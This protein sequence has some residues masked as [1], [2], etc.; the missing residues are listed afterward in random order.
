MRLVVLPL[1]ATLLAFHASAQEPWK[2]PPRGPV[3]QANKTVVFIASDYKNG[4]VIGVYRGFEQATAELGWTLT[5]LDGGGTKDKQAALLAKVVASRPDG[6]VFGGFDPDHFANH[7]AAAKR[8]KIVLVGW[9]AAKDP[10]PTKNLF[11]NVATYSV[12]VAKIA[13]EFVIRDAIAN[14][15]SVGVVIFN[16]NQYAVAN[17]KTA[18]MKKTVEACQ[19]HKACKVLAVENVLI[20][21]A[22]N[23]IPSLV[24]KLNATHGAAWTYS[25]AINDV[26]FDF[27]NYPLITAQRTDILNISAGDGSNKAFGRIGAGISQQAATVAEPLKMQGYQLADELN[28]AFAGEGPSGYVSKPILVTTK[29]LKETSEADIES[30]LGF[31]AAYS[32]LWYKK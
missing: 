29:L 11:V 4:G 21:D 3:A 13:A 23:A 5:M 22:A 26:Y 19:G 27:I 30:K 6:I 17:A 31:E 18:A 9:H 7:V 10:G 32:A 8:A 16:D 15:K 28:R 24:P 20:S 1:I 12:D 25:L 14:K 2:G